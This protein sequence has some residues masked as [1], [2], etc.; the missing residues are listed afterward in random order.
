MQQ[1][2]NGFFF[3]IEKEYKTLRQ[4]CSNQQTN[5]SSWLAIREQRE[6]INGFP[7]FSELE[8]FVFMLL[9]TTDLFMIIS[10]LI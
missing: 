2:L 10:N 6:S 9:R 7:A 3:L 4:Y 1:V 8:D 5:L